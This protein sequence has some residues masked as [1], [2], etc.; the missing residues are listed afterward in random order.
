MSSWHQRAAIRRAYQAGQ[1]VS[2]WHTH[3][4]QWTVRCEGEYGNGQ[5]CLMRYNTKEEAQAYI[6]SAKGYHPT[7]EFV[8]MAPHGQ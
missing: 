3:P 6:D 4:T 5:T 7:H 1:D 2:T 8:L